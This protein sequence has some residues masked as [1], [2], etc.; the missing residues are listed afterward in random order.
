MM[1]FRQAAARRPLEPQI[2]LVAMLIATAPLVQ[3][4]SF[5]QQYPSKP[6]RFI[7]PFPPG[8]PTDI[9]GRLAAQR[10]SE[11]WGV[12]IVPDNRAGAGGNIGFEMCAKSPPDGYTMCVM[13]VAQSISP[14][15]YRKI[16]FDPL[17]DFEHV[18][19]LGTQP[20][21][22]LVHPSLP[23]RNVMQLVAL[24]KAKPGVLNYAST[25]NGTS[26]HMMMEMFKSMAGVNL[27]HIPYKGAAPAMVDQISGLVE[28]AF[29]TAIAALSFVHQGKVRALAVSTRERFP[30]LPELP[31]V[32][33]SGIKGFEASSWNGVSLPAGTPRS[34]VLKTHNELARLLK[35][36]ETREKLL[37]LG[38][39]AGGNTPEEFTLFIRTDIERW[40][41]VAKDAKVRL[42]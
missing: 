35:T 30:P 12:Q 39:I 9:L 27:V 32:E 6:V 37:A 24:A 2:V 25:G 14:S 1:I 23:A 18:T 42:D 31:T 34:I 16:G 13:T 3:Q 4:P 22:L 8:G 10:L 40:A 7:I 29:S 26:P 11:A 19:M 28:V 36:P 41:R 20:S 38:S 17:K 5:A 15:I 33:Q 21:L